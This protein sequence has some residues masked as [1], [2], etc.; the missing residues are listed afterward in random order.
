MKAVSAQ[1]SW[2]VYDKPHNNKQHVH[3]NIPYLFFIGPLKAFLSFN[4]A[5]DWIWTADV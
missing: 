1:M 3:D 4:T 2:S 5:E